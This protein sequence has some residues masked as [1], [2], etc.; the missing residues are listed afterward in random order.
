MKNLDR[1][2]GDLLD[3]TRIEAGQLVLHVALHDLRALILDAVDLQ[4][5]GATI[6]E[7]DVEL[8]DGPLG[9]RCD[10]ARFSQV[11]NNLLSN[12][13]KYSPNGGTIAVIARRDR[14][15]IEVAVSDEGIGIDAT[16][17]E[18]IFTPFKR[19]LATKSTIPGVGLGLSASRRIIQAHGGELSVRSM[20]GRG[21][22]FTIRIPAEV[23]QDALYTS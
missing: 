11:M 13:V 8:P 19:T 17:L 15:E 5:A 14:D 9:C 18:N 3:T 23:R 21:S 22:T 16:D 2:V 1:L 7:L 10:S 12:A 6:H 20:P 4:R